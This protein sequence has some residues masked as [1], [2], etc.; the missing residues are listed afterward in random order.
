MF[1]ASC[2]D[3]KDNIDP[4]SL[5]TRPVFLSFLPLPLFP[6]HHSLCRL[7]L[8]C[9][10]AVS[11]LCLQIGRLYDRIGDFENAIRYYSM[12]KFVSQRCYPPSLPAYLLLPTSVSV[13]L[14]LLP[15]LS[16]S[17]CPCY[18]F[19][20]WFCL[21]L[22]LLLLPLQHCES[23]YSLLHS[24]CAYSTSSYLVLALNISNQHICHLF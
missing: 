13:S 8:P 15:H 23:S 16:L 5:I 22:Y 3:S 2:F 4:R 24:R 17:L 14:L 7:P 11:L 10:S 6:P 12:G 1:H 21:C 18:R 20:F 9:S 19:C